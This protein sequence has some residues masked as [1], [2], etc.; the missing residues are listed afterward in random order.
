MKPVSI[1][2]LAGVIGCALVHP[3]SA[4]D[5]ATY[6]EKV[7]YSFAGGADGA[8]PFAGVL[9]ANGML[10]GTTLFGGGTNNDG[11]VFAI[12]R[13]SG[14]ETVLYSFCSQKSCADGASPYDSLIDVK[15]MLY[16]TTLE[17]GSGFSGTA[18]S[19][20]PNS[21]MENTLYSFCQQQNCS[22]GANPIASVIDVGGTLYGTTSDGGNGSY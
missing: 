9:H 7:L 17:G 4:A 15:G 1:V 20:D 21:G 5:I 14:A 13:V 22:D 16:G 6:K 10:Y 3:V 12:N 11:T 8:Y 19:L 2:V 18:F